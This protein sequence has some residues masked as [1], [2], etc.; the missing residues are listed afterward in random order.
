MWSRAWEAPAEELL[1]AGRGSHMTFLSG[2]ASGKV[3]V[4]SKEPQSSARAA[5]LSKFRVTQ[6]ESRRETC[7]EERGAE[8]GGDE[9]T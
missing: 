7:W 4:L 5:A 2:V 9:R 3:P 1:G 8:R 6:K